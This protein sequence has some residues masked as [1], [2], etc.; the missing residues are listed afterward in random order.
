MSGSTVDP[1]RRDLGPRCDVGAEKRSAR[2]TYAGDRLTSRDRSD[3]ER[4][5]EP[6]HSEAPLA[7][8][9]EV[10]TIGGDAGRALAAAQGGVVRRLLAIV[11]EMEVGEWD[12]PS[13]EKDRR[14][15]VAP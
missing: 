2:H 7:V 3:A 4:R 1:G 15:E 14:K 9:F 11:A 6:V 13:P 12:R 10:R 8:R 5:H